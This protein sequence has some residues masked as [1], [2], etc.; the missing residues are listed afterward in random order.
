MDFLQGRHFLGARP[1]LEERAVE[2]VQD[3]SGK[4]GHARVRDETTG[5]AVHAV[6]GCQRLHLG[7]EER[8]GYLQMCI[9]WH[10]YVH[11]L[12]CPLNHDADQTLQSVFYS[13]YF[14]KQP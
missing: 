12:V 2:V 13:F 3:H 10:Q 7:F 6:V 11:F 1:R 8:K 4:R 9:S 5:L 14:I